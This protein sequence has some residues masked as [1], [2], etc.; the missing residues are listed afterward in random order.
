M[1]TQD[2]E[3]IIDKAITLLEANK[4]LATEQFFEVVDNIVGKVKDPQI[5][6][7]LGTM[8]GIDPNVVMSALHSVGQIIETEKNF[9][10]DGSNQRYIDILTRLKSH[11]LI[12]VAVANI[13]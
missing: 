10:K 7:M 8:L 12:M 2:L 13:L 9:L 1:K 4:R 5:A 3:L 6:S 11:Y